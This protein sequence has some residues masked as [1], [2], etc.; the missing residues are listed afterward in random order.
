MVI[1]MSAPIEEHV[2]FNLGDLL[3]PSG[4][5]AD[6]AVI[7]LHDPQA[8]RHVSHGDIYA[9]ARAV[10]RLLHGRGLR[11]GQRV[12]ILSGNRAEYLSIYSGIARAGLVAVPL[13][14]KAPADLIGYVA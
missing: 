11:A 3:N 9:Q 5:P 12:G 7:D 4:D 13:N 10:A 1:G 8:P 6:L 2:P 14:N